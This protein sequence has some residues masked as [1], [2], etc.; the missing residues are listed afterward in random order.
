MYKYIYVYIHTHT[1]IC[2]CLYIF[3]EVN[4]FKYNLQEM[5]LN[6]NFVEM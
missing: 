5:L 6:E 4:Q 3:Q 1:Y 2:E